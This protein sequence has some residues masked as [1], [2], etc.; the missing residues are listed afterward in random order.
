MDST[1]VSSLLRGLTAAG[2]L[3]SASVHLQLW[4]QGVRVVPVIGEA[5]ILNAVGGLVLALLVLTWRN[6][7]PL[8]GAIGFGL[9]T[10]AAFGLSVTVGLFGFLEQAAGVPQL[11]AAAS[12]VAAVV[13]AAAALVVE[14]RH[15]LP[16]TPSRREAHGVLNTSP[17]HRAA[18]AA[19][20]HDD[21]RRS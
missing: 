4:A 1:T 3:L 21:A 14:H 19:P 6:P 7:L 16:R 10:L 2:V 11:L 9:S 12:E 20:V 13:F 17:V 15:P 5:F 18:A 8:L